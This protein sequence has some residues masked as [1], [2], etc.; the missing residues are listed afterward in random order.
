MDTNPEIINS[1]RPLLPVAVTFASPFLIRVMA[2]DENRREA[3]SF[4]MASITFLTVITMAPAI[5]EGHIYSFTLFTI[6]PGIRVGFCA[7]G[8][9]MVFAL[10]S[11]FLWILTT[12]YNIGYMRT[13]REHAQTRYYVCFS[14]AIF[15]AQGVSFAGNVFTLYLF[16]EI[17]TLFTYPLVAHYQNR[18]AFEAGRKYLVYL[19]GTSKLFFLPAMILTYVLCGTLDFRLGDIH[20]GIFPVT[21]NPVLVISVYVLYLAGLTKT[22]MMPLHGW[23]PSAMVAP[24]PVSGLLHAVAVVKAGAFSV[25]RIMLSCFGLDS[26]DRLGLGTPTVYVAGFTIIAAALIALTK[27]DLK[28]RIAY[29]TVSHLSYIVMGVAMLSQG[30]VEGGISAIAHDAFPKITLFFAAGCIIVVTGS[31]KISMMNG[32][33]RRMPWT[34]GAFAL[35]T[36]SF[37]GLAPASGFL[38]KFYLITG[39]AD[40]KQTIPMVV[41]LLS[42]LLNMAYFGPIVIRGFFLPPRDRVEMGQYAEAPMTM[43]VPMFMIALLSILIG[44]YPQAFVDFVD[45]YG[46]FW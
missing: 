27:D 29:S 2:G 17:I 43:V 28:A 36:L 46:R 23:L 40:A 38:S 26:L 22:A 45:A 30:G 11:S 13:L 14:V 5:L 33:G 32:L 25:C 21:A 19:L 9:S 10:I 42:V 31:R 18:E 7:D 4:V 15:G 37:I 20:K 44:F 35:A 8:L 12:S 16:Y 41:I 24:T 6:L 39:A 34:F 3:L 1:V